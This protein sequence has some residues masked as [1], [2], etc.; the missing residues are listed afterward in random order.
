MSIYNLAIS[1][2]GMRYE[3]HNKNGLKPDT[4]KDRFCWYFVALIRKI[5][6]LKNSWKR[7]D[8]AVF[9][10]CQLQFDEKNGENS[11]VEKFVEIRQE[12]LWKFFG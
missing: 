1:L 3:V 2:I 11:L 8:F 5:L 9:V 6:W 7:N 4:N 10:C 12:K